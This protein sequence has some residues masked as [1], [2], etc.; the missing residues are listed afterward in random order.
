[1][2]EIGGGQHQQDGGKKRRAWSGN[3]AG[4]F[5]CS[6][7]AEYS[8]QRV[9]QV[10]CFVVA[11]RR[12]A[13]G[14]RGGHVEQPSVKVDVDIREGGSVFESGEVVIQA[15]LAIDF[16]ARPIE[17]DA[18]VGEYQQRDAGKDNQKGIEDKIERG[19]S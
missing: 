15:F 5:P 6:Q 14:R 17:T 13:T 10:A 4:Q 8:N 19:T 12:K 9:K 18:V 7:D 2:T 3:Q 1:M 16:L 11:Q